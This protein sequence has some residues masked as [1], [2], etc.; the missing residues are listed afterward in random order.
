SSGQINSIRARHTERIIHV[1]QSRRVTIAKVPT[2]RRRI[3]RTRIIK[4]HQKR[5]N[6]TSH[7][8]R[9]TRNRKLRIHSN[10]NQIRR[11]LTSRT[12]NRINIPKITITRTIQRNNRIRI[13]LNSRQTNSRT[14]SI[15]TSK[16]HTSSINQ[17]RSIKQRI[18]RSPSTIPPLSN[19]M[20]HIRHILRDQR[21]SLQLRHRPTL[22]ITNITS[23]K[24]LSINILSHSTATTNIRSRQT[25]SIITHIS[26]RV[27]R[28]LQS[29]KT[30]VTKTPIPSTRTVTR[31]I[32]ELYS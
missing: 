11:P 10:S 5:S 9:E 13:T 14:I 4:P 31:R 2:P 27:N 23:N 20:R 7:V 32:R 18:Q 8:S 26:K 30:T 16:R 15:R 3:Q 29:T 24:Q 21:Q 25:H 17:T 22:L 6:T 12:L 19:T 1:L 28:T